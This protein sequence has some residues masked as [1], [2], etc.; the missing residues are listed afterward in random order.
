MRYRFYAIEQTMALAMRP[1]TRMAG[2]RLYVLI[3]ESACRGDWLD[4]ARA[5]IRG[6][7]DC[8]Q[9]RE[10]SL[11][12]GEFLRRARAFVAL[13]REHGVISIINDRPDIALLANADGVHLGQHDLPATEAR[14]LMGREKII[15][16]STHQIEQARQAVADGA[17]YIGVGPVFRS[18][19]KPREFLP[20]LEYAGQ[21]AR[22]IQ[23]PAV[24]IAGITEQNV[25]QV[26]ATGLRAVAVTAAIVGCEDAESAARRFKEKLSVGSASADETARPS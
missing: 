18:S 12:G 3:T 15:G 16:V 23:I 22:E 7:A 1:A 2:V 14:K 13:C 9:L 20:G 11:E 26:L 19:T 24:A 10:K 21:V 6:G 17:D 8:L 4:T 25:D 5:A